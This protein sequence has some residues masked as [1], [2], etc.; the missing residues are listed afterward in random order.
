MGIEQKK[1]GER[2]YNSNTASRNGR[3]RLGCI[4]GGEGFCHLALLPCPLSPVSLVMWGNM[5]VGRF[6][7]NVGIGWMWRNGLSLLRGK[8]DGGGQENEV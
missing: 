7:G 2:G 8:N 1:R 6:W 3:R 4:L 5:D